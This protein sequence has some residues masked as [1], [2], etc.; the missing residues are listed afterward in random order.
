MLIGH[1]LTFA[2]E[3]HHEPHSLDWL[4][5]G[6]M[7]LHLAG[8][9]IGDLAKEHCSLFHAIERICEL[10]R[11]LDSLWDARLGGHTDA[12]IFAWLEHELYIRD[13]AEAASSD[14][15]RFDFLTNT[16]EQFDAGKSFIYCRPD[17]AVHI[18][19]DRHDG[20]FNSV[21]CESSELKRQARELEVWFSEQTQSG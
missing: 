14:L 19:F 16:G 8:V 9:T 18:L 13:S 15:A 11:T 20:M 6:R 21:V 5:F 10:G 1:P 7:C 12:E 17:G 4:G 3:I 2:I